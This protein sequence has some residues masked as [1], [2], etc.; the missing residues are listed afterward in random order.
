[1]TESLLLL[2]ASLALPVIA[3]L[4]F[5]GCVGDDPAL[6]AAKEEAEKKLADEKERQAQQQASDQIAQEAAKY[7]NVIKAESTLVSYWRLD[8]LETGNT[9]AVDSAPVA[10][11]NGEYKFL[12]GIAR[13]QAGALVAKDANDKSAQFKGTQGFVEVPYDGLRNPPFSFTVE[14]WMLPEGNAADPQV[15]IGSYELGALGVLLRGFVLDVLRAP[16]L[17]I[18]ARLGNGTDSTALE[19]DLGDGT[20]HSGWRHV[21][22]TYN[23]ATKD[24]LLYVNADD[25]KPDAQLP[26]PSAPAAVQYA[27]ISGPAMPIRIGAGQI[28]GP[29]LGAPGAPPLGSVGRFFEGRLDE[30]AIYRDVLDGATVKKHYT[31]S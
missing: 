23:G 6:V 24:L 12:L 4:T 29:V 14:F 9:T 28:E 27:A 30:V 13:G 15:V 21:V 25:G 3:L 2:T 22:M 20:Q 8:E 11:L 5:A 7:H 16:T 10:P 1:M 18:R 26:T 31:A 17:R 19:A